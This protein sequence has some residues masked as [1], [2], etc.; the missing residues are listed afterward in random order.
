MRDEE[1]DQLGSI[2]E[3]LARLRA[4]HEGQEDRAPLLAQLADLQAEHARLHSLI[5]VGQVPAAD[6]LPRLAERVERLRRDFSP[7]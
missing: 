1:R 2:D 7:P 6:A 4:A 5:L 3:T